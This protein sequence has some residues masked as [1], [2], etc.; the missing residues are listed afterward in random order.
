MKNGLVFGKY[1]PFHKG[2]E[3]LISFAA[4]QCD[5]LFVVVCAS[6][7][8]NIPS[9][10]RL[11][12]IKETF[13]DN[14]KIEIIELNYD[15][16]V[17]PNTSDSSLEVSKIWAAKFMEILPAIDLLVTSEPYGD[18]VANFMDAKHFLFDLDR[19]RVPISATQIRGSIYE[20]WEYLP[21]AV[22]KHYQKKVVFLGTECT[23]KSSISKALS[24]Q[25]N[26]SLV[27]EVGRD[28][29]ENSEEFSTQQLF[30]IAKSHAQNIEKSCSELKPFVFIDTD[31]Y[32]TQSYARFAFGEYLDIPQNIYDT[33]KA[34]IYFYLNNDLEFIQDGTR[35]EEES[36]NLLHLSH[37]ETLEK[38]GI[39]FS[40]V[41]G[42]WQNRYN[43]ILN[44]L[45]KSTA[46]T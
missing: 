46:I 20:N 45:Q 40:K 34:N 10:V 13:V 2:H 26:S 35:M 28:I 3:A 36:R 39:P 6:Q 38:F 22:K 23:G 43:E 21:D 32:I 11:N 41:S 12:W 27:D 33:N 24:E 42:D 30:L 17:L 16:S 25:F 8:E 14:D 1:Y 4:G 18:Y 7:T 29:V 31:I 37:I 15:E 9:D 19:T 44:I 5:K